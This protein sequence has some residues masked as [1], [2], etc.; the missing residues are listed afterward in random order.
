MGDGSEP[1]AVKLSTYE[2]DTLEMGLIFSGKHSGQHDYYARLAEDEAESGAISHLCYL[3][4]IELR[5]IS[6]SKTTT[7]CYLIRLTS[8]GDAV[9]RANWAAKKD[10]P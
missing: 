10:R 5:T 9:L 7:R 4:L 2:Q 6:F 8:K 3:N 1:R